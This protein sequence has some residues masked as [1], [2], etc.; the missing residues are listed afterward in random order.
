MYSSNIEDLGHEIHPFTKV[1][2]VNELTIRQ[3]TNWS[4]YPEQEYA[5][6]GDKN[7]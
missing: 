5:G 6:Q 2:M 4:F 1:T 7:K 3:L